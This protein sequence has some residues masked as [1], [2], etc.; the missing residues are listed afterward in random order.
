MFATDP[1]RELARLYKH[2]RSLFKTKADEEQADPDDPVREAC[3]Q[4]TAKLHAGDPE[5]VRLWKMFM[6]HCHELITQIYRRLDVS[7]DHM[8]GE[9]FYNP[10]LAAVV[11]E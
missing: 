10:M 8:L 5:N 2:V 9:S 7:F 4:E 6:P 11:S 3:R 1:A